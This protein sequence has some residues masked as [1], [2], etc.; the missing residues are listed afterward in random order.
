MGRGDDGNGG[1]GDDAGAGGSDGAGAGGR[2]HSRLASE[3]LRAC[4]ATRPAATL[5]I[6]SS[7]S[8]LQVRD[9]KEY[10]EMS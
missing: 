1:G 6:R 8:N 4:R 3:S 2:S 7:S 5:A 9:M 10:F